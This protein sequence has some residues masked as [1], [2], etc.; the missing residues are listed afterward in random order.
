MAEPFLGE[1][2]MFGFRFAPLGWALCDGSLLPVQQN[3]PLFSL[4]GTTYGGDGLRTFALPDLR[5][6]APIH[7]GQGAG[8]SQYNLGESGGQESVALTQ[9]QLPA[10]NHPANGSTSGGD[11]LVP[12]N[13]VWSADASGGS[14]PYTD[15][16]PNVTL[17]PGAIGPAGSNLPHEN[18]QP[19]LALNFSIAL[20]GIYPTQG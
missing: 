5:G 3:A 6:R 9:A 11:K 14:A 4:I 1:I 15:E 12:D 16:P 13:G 18:R 20:E 2:R 19:Y 7:F 10:H 17:A 8:L